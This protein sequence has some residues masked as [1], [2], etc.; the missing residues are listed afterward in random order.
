MIRVEMV[1]LPYGSYA[2][3]RRAG[4]EPGGEPIRVVLGPAWGAES[5]WV[6]ADRT[7][8]V[9]IGERD[10]YERRH[11]LTDEMDAIGMWRPDVGSYDAELCGY[12]HML[13]ERV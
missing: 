6:W 5:V 12:G 8:V 2:F 9:W 3:K 4:L 11:E 1:L 10:D 7:G 13:L